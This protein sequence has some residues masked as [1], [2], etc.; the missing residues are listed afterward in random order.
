MTPEMLGLLRDL[1][2]A[3]GGAVPG[4]AWT[5]TAATVLWILSYTERP[6]A[7][8]PVAILEASPDVV[9]DGFKDAFA[10][11]LGWTPQQFEQFWNEPKF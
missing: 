9:D 6:Q 3:S 5:A 1:Y 10:R 2:G 8:D 11:R 4:P 7:V